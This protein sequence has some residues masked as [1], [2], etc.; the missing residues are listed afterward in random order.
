MEWTTSAATLLGATIA[1]GSTV[2]VEVRKDRRETAAEWR[3][4]K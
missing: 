1:M 3:R 2:L 4:S